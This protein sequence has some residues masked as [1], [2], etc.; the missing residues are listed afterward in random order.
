MT[1]LDSLTGP[2]GGPCTPADF[3]NLLSQV[4]SGMYARGW[5]VIGSIFKASRLHPWKLPNRETIHNW[6]QSDLAAMRA[7]ALNLRLSDT[8]TIAL[9]CDFTYPRPHAA[10]PAAGA[11]V[12][13]AKQERHVHVRRQ[14]GR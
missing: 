14:K 11:A 5:T 9:D 10:L 6:T 7:N 4:E 2:H 1:Y 8:N 13:G 12:S 3:I